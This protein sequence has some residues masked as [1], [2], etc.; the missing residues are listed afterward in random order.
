MRQHNSSSEDYS[1]LCE[2]VPRNIRGFVEASIRSGCRKRQRNFIYG[3]PVLR[4]Q[5]V[6]VGM[7]LYV[8]MWRGV[9]YSISTY[10]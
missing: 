5:H 6:C 1:L 10:H 3:K 7:D 2:S 4:I 9:C 8:E